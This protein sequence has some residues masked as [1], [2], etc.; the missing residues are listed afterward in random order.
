MLSTL[1]WA[2]IAAWQEAGFPLQAV[3]SGVDA[4]FDKYE[5]RKAKGRARRINGLAYCTQEVLRAVEDMHEAATGVNRKQQAAPPE[6]GFESVRIAK[7]LR[8]AAE[9]LR[10]VHQPGEAQPFVSGIADKL[11][12]HADRF[13]NPD[14]SA[15]SLSLESLEQK[16]LTLEDQL[17]ATLQMFSQP[18]KLAA[19]RE[20]SAQELAPY[21]SRMQ[22][23]QIRQI[24]QQFL[25][26]R[27]FEESN[28]PRLSL[29][30]MAQK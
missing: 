9:Q 7:Y 2:L 8:H 25:R 3:L 4:T 15:E 10:G 29:F 6:S 23:M 1:D 28:L 17:F 12:E 16:L 19:L 27:L 26:R 24:E 18:D 30:Y 22:A 21:R 13:E 14:A 11:I 5:T 20:Q